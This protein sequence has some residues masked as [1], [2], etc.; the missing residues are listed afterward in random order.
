MVAV[1]HMALGDEH[2]D[3]WGGC[4]L[5]G[6]CLVSALGSEPWSFAAYAVK[7]QQSQSFLAPWS[8]SVSW[9]LLKARITRGLSFKSCFTVVS[10]ICSVENWHVS[11]TP[12]LFLSVCVRTHSCAWDQKRG[13]GN[14]KKTPGA[15]FT[16]EGKGPKRNFIP[17]DK[18]PF[19]V[20]GM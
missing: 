16:F 11:G 1:V 4:H 12:P 13:P 6:F 9:A 17:P 10:L 15:K 5:L 19:I 8:L 7:H 18:I 3:F 14:L 20:S 2:I